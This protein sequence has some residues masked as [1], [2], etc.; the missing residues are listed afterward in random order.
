M[1]RGG[2]G[3]FYSNI[4]TEGGMQSMEV[5]P[6]WNVR[7]GLQPNSSKPPTLFLDQGFAAGR[8][9]AFERGQRAADFLR[10]EQRHALRTSS[11]ISISS[12]NC[13]A[14]FYWRSATTE[15]SWITCGGRSTAIP[16][17]RS[18]GRST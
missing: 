10:P 4:I 15:T 1:F 17:L 3:I 14:A 8:A 12:G 9:V 5:N 7:I 16:R 11:G 6:P 18:R 2:Y 13:P